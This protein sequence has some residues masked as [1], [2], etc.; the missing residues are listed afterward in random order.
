MFTPFFFDNRGVAI[1]AKLGII[2]VQKII[3]IV[4][5][6]VVL[7]MLGLLYLLL[8][9][10]DP[11]DL[12][13]SKRMMSLSSLQADT[14]VYVSA[15]ESGSEQSQAISDML[16]R[17]VRLGSELLG[18]ELFVVNSSGT[19]VFH[20]KP[21]MEGRPA[22][23]WFNLELI[24]RP[25]IWSE[26]EIQGIPVTG[27]L[28]DSKDGWVVGYLAETAEINSHRNLIWKIYLFILSLILIVVPLLLLFVY[29]NTIVPLRDFAARAR[30]FSKGT[31]VII[32]DEYFIREI[33]I[34]AHSLN[35]MMEAVM[36][37]EE[38]L[39]QL[40]D[41]L[42]EKVKERTRAHE[43][44]IETLQTA[45]AQLLLSEKM[46]VLGS[47][48]S[49]VAHE[50]NTPLGIGI[51]A[52]SFLNER[53]GSILGEW[54]EKTLTQEELESFLK[55]TDESTRIIQ[56]NL[57]HAAK[58]LNSLKRVA[59]DQQLDECREF[60]LCAYIEDIILSLKHQLKIGRH[61]I[62]LNPCHTVLV[63]VNPGIITQILNNLVFNSVSHGFEGKSG[64]RIRI[65]CREDG[66]DIVLD[67]EDDGRGLTEEEK[68]HIFD[69]FFT[70]RRDSGGTGLGM[71]IVYSLVTEKL[72]GEITVV[73]PETGG[74]G[75]T[76]R[77]PKSFRGQ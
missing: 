2:Q 6:A 65:G 17:S 59:V 68:E 11:P 33:D 77:F 31:P 1:K 41:T 24:P 62:E 26:F 74:A 18:G 28:K 61:Q 48:V 36:N 10:T 52:A 75:F 35:E 27:M 69:Q 46:S 49:G 71:H 66:D 47:L 43:E 70:T 51:T 15:V 13:R 22:F 72:G 23:S 21:E 64:G 14:S 38:S 7:I 37:R 32:R 60:E 76:I 45:R 63:R 55:D 42:E 25:G 5:A 57:E 19:I 44:T 54:N 4:L 30:V 67:Y 3:A 73:S 9:W 8:S 40:T 16:E 20:T 50:I 58:I 29:R 12:W 56:S 34:L 53:S 39:R